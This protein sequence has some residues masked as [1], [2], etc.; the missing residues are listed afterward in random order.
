M[1][2]SF[3]FYGVSNLS[4]LIQKI[5]N[6]YSVIFLGI[7]ASSFCLSELE[8]KDELEEVILSTKLVE[9]TVSSQENKKA[10]AFG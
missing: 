10:S 2:N 3:I 6:L 8:D 9:E 1:S 7:E 4:A 5:Y